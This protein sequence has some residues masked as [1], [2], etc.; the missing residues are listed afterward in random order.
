MMPHAGTAVPAQPHAQKVSTSARTNH[1]RDA[2]NALTAMP[3]VPL[4]W[5]E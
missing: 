4:E 3:N 5:Y 2:Q 1:S